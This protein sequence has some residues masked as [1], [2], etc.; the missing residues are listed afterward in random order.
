MRDPSF[1]A[2]SDNAAQVI[3]GA[4]RVE[5]L[6][7]EVLVVFVLLSGHISDCPIIECP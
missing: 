4:G 2:Q 6:V 3:L 1:G 7:H 5:R